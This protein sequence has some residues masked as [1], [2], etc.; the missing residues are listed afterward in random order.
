MRAALRGALTLSAALFVMQLVTTLP[1]GAETV[2][3]LKAQLAERDAELAAQVQINALQ[4]QRI[5]TL[6]AEL[7]GRKI[8]AAPTSK[9]SP[10]RA[11][12]DRVRSMSGYRLPGQNGHL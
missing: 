2:E 11:A 6:E 8:A 1:A 5:E 9:Q 3:E 4:R 12:G 10:E 7:A